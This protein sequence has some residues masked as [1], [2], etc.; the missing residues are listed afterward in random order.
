MQLVM[1]VLVL[2]AGLYVALVGDTSQGIRLFGWFLVLIGVSGVVIAVLVRR[3]S[4][5]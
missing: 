5:G 4:R 2:V 1:S 3:R